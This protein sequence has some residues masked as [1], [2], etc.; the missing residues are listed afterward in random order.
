MSELRPFV[1][2]PTGDYLKDELEALGW[3][4]QDFAE[5][6][7]MSVKG[8]NEILNSKTALTIE[9]AQLIGSAFGTSAQLWLGIDAKYR[10]RLLEDSEREKET[11]LQASIRRFMPVRE[12]QK[13]GWLPPAKSGAEVLQAAQD[14]WQVR[15]PTVS[16]FESLREPSYRRSRSRE[17]F[18]KYYALSWKQK[19]R[20]EAIKLSLAAYDSEKAQALAGRIAELTTQAK[21]VEMAITELSNAG[22]GFLVLTHLPKTYLDGA[23]LIVNERPF[24]LYTGRF[25]RLDH[26]WFT[27]AHELAHIVLGHVGIDGDGILDEMNDEAGDDKE[28]EADLLAA[29]WLRHDKI[30]AY[31]EPFRQYVSLVRVEACAQQVGVHPALVVGTL[32]YHKYL[33]FKNLNHLKESV[34][35]RIPAELRVG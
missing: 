5:V 30:L 28:R 33:S 1:N 23:A 25:D 2:I 18:E 35:N 22:V 9:T 13:K 32:Q 31:C 6:L 34:L 29:Q 12:M 21:G 11:S 8:V 16:Y 19:A 15:E 10:L 4:Q 26:F 7:G 27:L 14:F 24:I 20:R 3:T 17:T